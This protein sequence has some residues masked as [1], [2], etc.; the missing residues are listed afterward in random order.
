MPIPLY[1]S[2]TAQEISAAA[3]LPEQLAYMACHFSLYGSGLSN[4]PQYLPENTMIILNDFTP[5]DGHEPPLVADQLAALSEK[6]HSPFVLLDLQR[7]E[8]PLT[9]SIAK[10]ILSAVPCP[11]IVSDVY[12]K[13]LQCPVFLSAIAC[14]QGLQS[15]IRP[16]SGREIWLEISRDARIITVDRSGSR[17]CVCLPGDPDLLPHREQKLHCHYRIESEQDLFRFTLQRTAEDLTE[18]LLEAEE[19][20]V[21]GAIGLYQELKPS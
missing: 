17:Q 21:V 16:W 1:L 6:F 5:P 14:H 9:L 8:N 13:D 7:P 18:L 4:F 12:A 3:K 20:G 11:V 19:L 15:H 2:M 10:A